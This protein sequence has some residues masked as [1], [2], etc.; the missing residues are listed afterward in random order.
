MARKAKGNPYGGKSK[1]PLAKLERRSR[2]TAKALAKSLGKSLAVIRGRIVAAETPA[3]ARTQEE[4][5]ADIAASFAR[6]GRGLDKRL[7]DDVASAATDAAHRAKDASGGLVR[8]DESRARRYWRYV[9]PSQGKNLAA[10]FTNRMS[11]NLINTLR[12]SLVEVE[13]EAAIEGMTANEKQKAVQE[14][15]A[16]TCRDPSAFKFVDSA[17]KVWENARYLQMLSRTTAQRVYNDSYADRLAE[18]GCE[19]AR[20]VSMGAP[21][22]KVCAAWQNQIVA[23]SGKSEKFPTLAEARAAGVF[24]PNCL[25]TLEYIDEDIEADEIKRQEEAGKVNWEDPDAVQARADEIAIEGMKADGMAEEEAK[26]AL[27]RGK[28]EDAI[29]AGLFTDDAKALASSFT[30]EQLA[31]FRKDGV[32]RFQFAKKGEHTGW[33]HGGAGGVVRIEDGDIAGGMKKIF[34]T[35]EK[36]EETR[37]PSEVVADF[38]NL[39]VEQGREAPPTIAGIGARM[40]AAQEDAREVIDAVFG[41]GA[42]ERI[43][44]NF[45]ATMREAFGKGSFAMKI[46]DSSLA[47]VLNPKN[48]HFKSCFELQGYNPELLE[49]RREVSESVMGAADS[50]PAAMREKYGYLASADAKLDFDGRGMGASTYGNVV[51]RFKKDMVTPTFTIGDSLASRDFGGGTAQAASLVSDPR[52]FAYMESSVP[53]RL[54]K[55]AAERLL[56]GKMPVGRPD[57]LQ[58][59]FVRDSSGK[60]YTELQYHGW[61]GKDAIESVSFPN[62]QALDAIGDK[63][64]EQLRELGAKVYVGGEPY[65]L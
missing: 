45:G 34:G 3:F 47:K 33:R 20:I 29:R 22:C 37:K 23:V 49:R 50:C 39:L 48:G 21:G 15:W 57:E 32:P 28:V 16:Q 61:L 9:A 53:D 17:G 1:D 46:S 35:E 11:D 44:R 63:A 43:D 30:R 62:T 40:D 10:V 58:H 25:C 18:A 27:T 8:W 55:A 31:E 24:H 60:S 56:K 36:K 26:D 13:R 5:F 12:Q 54:N 14:R 19:I 7:K 42:F 52:F 59:Q 4:L 65:A 38:V 51:V 2:V 41:N 64:K 6:F